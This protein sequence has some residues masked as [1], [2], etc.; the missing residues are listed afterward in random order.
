MEWK[1]E[2]STTD[3]FPKVRDELWKRNNKTIIPM[4]VQY[5]KQT[6]LFN[7]KEGTLEG[8]NKQVTRYRKLCERYFNDESKLVSVS[9]CMLCAS[10]STHALPDIEIH[11]VHYCRCEKCDLRFLKRRLSNEALNQFYA[12]DQVLTA[13]LT[14]KELVKKR[15][16]D[17]VI[18][19]VNW[20]INEYRRVFGRSPQKIVDVGAG[21]GHFVYAAR[22]LGLN[23]IGIEPNEPSQRFAKDVLGI[24]LKPEGFLDCSKTCEDADII[25]F[26][27][28]LEH[29]PDFMQ[30][31][32]T[33]NNI[34]KKKNNGLVVV[35]VPRW[36]SLGTEVQRLF[37]KAVNRHLFPL[38]HLMVFSDSSLANAFVESGFL[39]IG[40]WFFGMDMYELVLQF[41]RKLDNKQLIDEVGDMLLGFQPIIDQGFLSDTMVFSG[42]V[43]FEEK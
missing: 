12:E 41:A 17:I 27:A 38:T 6:D 35:E 8:F 11:G 23:A 40:A 24:D 25:T 28:V 42:V 3:N 32:R 29:I 36:H 18:P 7:L 39:P 4:H 31:L 30:F 21:A 16:E 22:K 19:K 1:R 2:F 5:G 14:D 26:W 10:D 13:T 33:A 9:K 43:N 37:S 20:S 34:L 15:I